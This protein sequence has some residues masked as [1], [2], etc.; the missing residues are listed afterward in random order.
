MRDSKDRVDL[1]DESAKSGAK[2]L[3]EKA[4]D[5]ALNALAGFIKK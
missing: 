3:G 4:V 2:K 1:I 5:C